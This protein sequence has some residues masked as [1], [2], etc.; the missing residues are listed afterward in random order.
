MFG[1]KG[2]SMV[3]IAV[4]VTIIAL[5][6]GPLIGVLSS[7]NR[8]S[9]AS[10]Y[11]EMAIHYGREISDQ[12]LRLNPQFSKIVAD[13]RALTGDSSLNMDDILNDSGFSGSLEAHNTLPQAVDLQISGTRL[14]VRIM[15]S[16]LNKAFTRR[17][18]VVESLEVSSNTSLNTGKYWKAKIELEW[19]DE[20]SGVSEPRKA[21]MVVFLNEN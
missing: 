5:A 18:I 14:P 12:L 9:N 3:E 2:L 20:N 19:L 1:K 6:V 8:M 7:S 10:I 4:S 21:V 11:E 17:R 13:A 16:A 15:V